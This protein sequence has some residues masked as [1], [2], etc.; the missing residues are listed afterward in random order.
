MYKKTGA[1]NATILKATAI[2]LLIT[3]S[4]TKRPKQVY[5]TPNP[6]TNFG[7]QDTFSDS[8]Y[9]HTTAQYIP[10][11]ILIDSNKAKLSKESKYSFEEKTERLNGPK[12]TQSNTANSVNKAL[13]IW[14]LSLITVSGVFMYTLGFDNPLGFLG[15]CFGILILLTGFVLALV[16]GILLMSK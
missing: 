1:K 3:I 4:C 6:T 11:Q 8:V 10:K 5:Y 14:G 2:I 13:L 9:A 7:M 16:G 12:S 15:G